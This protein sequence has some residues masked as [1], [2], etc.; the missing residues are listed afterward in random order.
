MAC[1]QLAETPLHES[2]GRVA[3]TRVV[4]GVVVTSHNCEGRIAALSQLKAY[5]SLSG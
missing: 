2:I 1:G 3:S 4:P 5:F